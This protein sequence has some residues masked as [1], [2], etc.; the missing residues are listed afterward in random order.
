MDPFVYLV[1]PF[2]IPGVPVLFGLRNALFLEQLS[3]FQRDYV[4]SAEEERT[5]LTDVEQRMLLKRVGNLNSEEIKD[6][7]ASV[8]TGAGD[9]VAK[10]ESLVNKKRDGNRIGLKD[11]AQFKRK[12]AKVTLLSTHWICVPPLVKDN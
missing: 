9:Q 1:K 12:R 2:Q 5:R 10:N 6:A 3:S 4:K 7:A 8:Q 11:K